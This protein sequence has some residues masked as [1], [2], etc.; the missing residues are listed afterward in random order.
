HGVK[1]F[2]GRSTLRTWLWRIATNK[3][4]DFMARRQAARRGG[5]L[6]ILSLDAVRNRAGERPPPDQ[7][8]AA[9]ERLREVRDALDA[10]GDPC[11]EILELRY[12]AD[13]DYAAIGATLDLHPKTVSSR[14]H[15]CLHR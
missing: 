9:A 1:S 12:F 7:E 10:L 8:L 2:E 13:A 6:R 4:R 3:A 15:R 11:R 14:L 5:G